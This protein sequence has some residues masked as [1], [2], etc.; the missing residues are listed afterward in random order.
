MLRQLLKGKKRPKDKIPFKKSKGKQK[1][2]E[3]S[4]FVNTENEEHSTLSHPNLH[5]KRRITQSTGALI[6]KR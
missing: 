5:L 4:S 6:P 2:V 1:E 3:S